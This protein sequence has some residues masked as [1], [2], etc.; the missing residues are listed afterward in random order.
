M[1]GKASFTQV[2]YDNEKAKFVNMAPSDVDAPAKKSCT[3]AEAASCKKKV[4][5]AKVV[6]TSV[7]E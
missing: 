5:A 2:S 3:K 7:K 6:K 1:S 4:K